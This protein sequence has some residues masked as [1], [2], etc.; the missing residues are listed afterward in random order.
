MTDGLRSTLAPATGALAGRS[1]PELQDTGAV[2]AGRVL[3]VADAAPVRTTQAPH[4]AP[5]RSRTA[6]GGPAVRATRP[7]AS[8]PPRL[9]QAPRRA[10]RGFGDIVQTMRDI[11][12]HT[13][14][15]SMTLL[16]PS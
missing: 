4:T 1:T 7:A 11:K 2:A 16:A 13:V 5:A 14:I 6:A 3:P 8:D 15:V 12:H 9:V 10:V